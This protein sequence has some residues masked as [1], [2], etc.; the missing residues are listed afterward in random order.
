MQTNRR[1]LCKLEIDGIKSYMEELM[2][3]NTMIKMSW[4]VE[5]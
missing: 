1:K 3:S 4:K 2:H 5:K